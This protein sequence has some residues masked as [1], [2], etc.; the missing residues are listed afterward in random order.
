MLEGKPKSKSKIG[1]IIMNTNTNTNI[2]ATCTTDACA[3]N[4]ACTCGKVEAMDNYEVATEAFVYG[5]IDCYVEARHTYEVRLDTA[6]QLAADASEQ[7]VDFLDMMMRKVSAAE[8]EKF[9]ESNELTSADRVSCIALFA[10]SHLPEDYVG[11]TDF[12]FEN[13]DTGEIGEGFDGRKE[14]EALI[15]ANAEA[16]TPSADPDVATLATLIT[17]ILKEYEK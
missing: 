10:K 15:N 16:G 4:C 17:R 6:Q 1:G 14:L 8:F 7:F 5:L 3:Q 13:D 11:G 12:S 2:P 9:I